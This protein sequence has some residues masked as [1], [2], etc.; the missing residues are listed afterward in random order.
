MRKKLQLETR[1]SHIAEFDIK[2]Y[3][4]WYTLG[5]F[6]I[7]SQTTPSIIQYADAVKIPFRSLHRFL[8]FDVEADQLCSLVHVMQVN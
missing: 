5:I 6:M 2:S 7:W 8:Q 1:S 3:L 4:V